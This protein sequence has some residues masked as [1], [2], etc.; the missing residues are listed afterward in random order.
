M[1]G[2]ILFFEESWEDSCEEGFQSQ[3]GSADDSDVEGDR[4]PDQSMDTGF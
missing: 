2:D 4:G 3:E 1:S